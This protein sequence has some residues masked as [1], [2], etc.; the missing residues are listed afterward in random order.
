MGLKPW[1]WTGAHRGL[2]LDEARWLAVREHVQA[3]DE[4][5]G[6]GLDHKTPQNPHGYWLLAALQWFGYCK[7]YCIDATPPE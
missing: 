3:V 1:W 2:G 4:F 5:G 6:L 7:S